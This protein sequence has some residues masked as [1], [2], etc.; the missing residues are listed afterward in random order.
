MANYLRLKL[1]LTLL[2]HSEPQHRTWYT[3]N[4]PNNTEWWNKSLR[5]MF[6]ILALSFTLLSDLSKDKDHIVFNFPPCLKLFS[7]IKY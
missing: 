3:A 5:Y 1:V 2:Y 7:D 4:T 6:I